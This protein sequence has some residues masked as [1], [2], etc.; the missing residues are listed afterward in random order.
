MDLPVRWIE[1]NDSRVKIVR[2]AWEDIKGVFRVRWKLWRGGLS[3][4]RRAALS[5]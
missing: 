1:D 2:T 5:A 4:A 3:P